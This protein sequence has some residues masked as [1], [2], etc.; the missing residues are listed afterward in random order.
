MCIGS[1]CSVTFKKFVFEGCSLA[2]LSGAQCTLIHT[3]FKVMGTHHA[4]I[5][6]Y[7][8]GV[9]TLVVF[10]TV[11]IVGGVQGTSVQDGAR[12]LQASNLHIT[13]VTGGGVKV[14]GGASS[15]ALYG[16]SM[17]PEEQD[18]AVP[19]GVQ[20]QSNTTAQLTNVTLSSFAYG[21]LVNT[22]A[23]AV[24]TDCTVTR[25][26]EVCVIFMSTV[27]SLE[28]C[29]LSEG[30]ECGLLANCEGTHVDVSHCHFLRCYDS[31]V[32][33]CNKAWVDAVSLY[34]LREWSQG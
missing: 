32:A 14:S 3:Q 13:K 2:G 25:A 11:S 19:F 29:T 4:G 34:K 17:L 10:K 20:V 6:L 27:G 5:S 31:G 23:T 21:V 24:L 9:G 15:L 8:Q 18:F 28:R 26:K 7:A 33:A 1:S 30:A 22:N 12:R 16:F